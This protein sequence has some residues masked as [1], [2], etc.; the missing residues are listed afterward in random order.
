L[1]VP[2][3]Q[4]L[5]PARIAALKGAGVGWSWSEP[6]IVSQLEAGTV[7]NLLIY[8]SPKTGT[9]VF[10]DGWCDERRRRYKPL[11]GSTANPELPDQHRMRAHLGA[12]LFLATGATPR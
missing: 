6:A 9:S 3:R 7:D 12:V 10:V 11:N 2:I 5:P 8:Y 4:L 1:S